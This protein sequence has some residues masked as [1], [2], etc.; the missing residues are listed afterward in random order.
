MR[1]EI[2]TEMKKNTDT[3]LRV[4]LIEVHDKFFVDLRVFIL[5]KK[6]QKVPTDQGLRFGCG[7]D[8]DARLNEAL[9]GIG[10][11]RERAK[12]MKRKGSGQMEING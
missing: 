9:A 4:T 5:T 8:N 6:K 12:E 3:F 11:A 1:S 7:P 2:I 10:K